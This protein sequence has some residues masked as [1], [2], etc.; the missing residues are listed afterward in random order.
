MCLSEQFQSSANSF[1]DKRLDTSMDMPIIYAVSCVVSSVDSVGI[2]M[3][4][5]IEIV[6]E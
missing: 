5:D 4:E 6:K 3:P 1:T 2:T